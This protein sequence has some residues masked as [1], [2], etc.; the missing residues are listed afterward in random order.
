MK[1]NS[2]FANVNSNRGNRHFSAGASAFGRS[3]LDTVFH[4]LLL[5]AGIGLSAAAA[6]HAAVETQATEAGAAQVAA[7]HRGEI[8]RLT[9]CVMPQTTVV[10]SACEMQRA[11]NNRS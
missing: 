9:Q 6:V 5:I 4:V 3:R 1:L 11:V 2:A 10:A 8:R 7:N